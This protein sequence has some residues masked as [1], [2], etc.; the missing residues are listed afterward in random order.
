M[1]DSNA[2]T[3]IDAGTWSLSPITKRIERIEDTRACKGVS[4]SVKGVRINAY[5]TYGESVLTRTR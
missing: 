3:R 5:W 4:A 1:F 2:C